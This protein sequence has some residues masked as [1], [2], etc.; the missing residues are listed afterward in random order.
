MTYY[1]A[2]CSYS[3]ADS[4]IPC[5]VGRVLVLSNP[6]PRRRGTFNVGRVLVLNAAPAAAYWLENAM[7]Q[8][9]PGFSVS[10]SR[11][12][13]SASLDIVAQV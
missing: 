10:A 3:N 9:G 11:R 6:P 12:S 4:A 5:N 7:M 13:A 1:Q 2:E 8:L